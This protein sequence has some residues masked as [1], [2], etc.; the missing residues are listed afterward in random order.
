MQHLVPPDRLR[1]LFERINPDLRR[2]N[3]ES[4]LQELQKRFIKTYTDLLSQ[5]RFAESHRTI[6]EDSESTDPAYE[7]KKKLAE[8]SEEQAR[9]IKVMADHIAKEIE[10]IEN[11]IEDMKKAG[12]DSLHENRASR[13]RNDRSN[14]TIEE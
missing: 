3:L 1:D 10:R 4:D 6:F 7:N 14:S 2:E 9:Q 5:D 8:A 12:S 13:R 11:V